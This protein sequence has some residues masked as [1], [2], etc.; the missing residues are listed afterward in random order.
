MTPIA[1]MTVVR[2][3]GNVQVIVNDIVS[4][5]VQR[6]RAQDLMELEILRKKLN[7]EMEWRD[8]ARQQRNNLLKEKCKVL[9]AKPCKTFKA[10]AIDVIEFPLACLIVWGEALKL[11]EHVGNNKEE[12]K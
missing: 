9:H 5:E 2:G 1:T 12:W 10:K 3:K 7:D 11:I 4:K 8:M 6:L